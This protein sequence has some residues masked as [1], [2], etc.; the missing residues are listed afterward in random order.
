MFNVRHKFY[1]IFVA[2]IALCGLTACGGDGGTSPVV[3]VAPPAPPLPPPPPPAG[4]VTISG[5]VT[6]EEVGV[7]TADFTLDL[8]DLTTL[9]ARGI[10]VEAVSA[11]GAVLATAIT[12][13]AGAY[14]ISVDPN[15]NVRIQ[16]RA[17]LLESLTGTPAWNVTIEDNTNDDALYV[18]A[19]SLTNSGATNSTRNLFAPS[20]SDG[21]SAY[22]S[23]R[24]AGPFFMLDEMLNGL[25]LIQSADTD[26]VLPTFRVLW[27]VN[28]RLIN[29]DE[30]TDISQGD[31]RSSFFSTNIGG[32]PS[33]V[34]LGDTLTDTD[35]YD[36]HVVTHELAHFLTFSANRDDSIGGSH[37]LASLL[38]PRVSF[39]EGFGNAFSAMATGDPLYIDA[40][41][42]DDG[43]FAFNLELNT[44]GQ[45]IENNN[46]IPAAGWYGESSTQ[47]ILYDL[48]DSNNDGVDTLSLG[49]GPLLET[50]QSSEYLDSAASTTIFNYLDAMID[51]GFVTAAQLEPYLSFQDIDGTGIFGVGETNN[52]GVPTAL[53]VFNT[54]TVGAAPITICSLDDT[55]TANRIGNRALIS[56][57]VPNS[58]SFT[59]RMT[60]IVGMPATSAATARDPDFFVFNQ[61]NFVTSGTSPDA[62][63]EVQVRTLPAGQLIVDA[64]D[65]NNVSQSDEVEPG[66]ACYA[67]SVQ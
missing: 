44:I 2:L 13:D 65:F 42:G 19:G 51:N 43:G 21:V 27:S 22:T 48:F 34:I 59:L 38:D 26:I 37:S 58:G 6:F 60:R 5:S 45:I 35:E 61:G 39:S 18:L 12:N 66:D 7:E 46:G 49:F 16:A 67:F 24:T 57:N 31:L 14:S 55:G 9:P 63:N 33:I 25:R 1:G 17:Q 41:F 64:F 32:M 40:G 29:D 30:E 28:N 3:A 53:P 47:S 11:T 54:Y 10:V 56:L 8:A 23:E 15:T 4:S 36:E 52:G 62:D 50:F 20:G